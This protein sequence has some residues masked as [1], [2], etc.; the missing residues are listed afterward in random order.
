VQPEPLPPE[1]PEPV[2]PAPAKKLTGKQSTLKKKANVLIQR[3]RNLTA[4]AEKYIR[5]IGAGKTRRKNKK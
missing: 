2:I 3:K 4:K 5:M 1:Q